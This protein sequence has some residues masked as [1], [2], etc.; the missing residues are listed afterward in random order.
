[1]LGR[2]SKSKLRFLVFIVFH[3]EH[4]ERMERR[5]F[6]GPEQ[7]FVFQVFHPEHCA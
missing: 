5:A 1:M 2:C 7:H 3:L 6:L 4:K